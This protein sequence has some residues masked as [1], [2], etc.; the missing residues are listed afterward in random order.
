MPTEATRRAF[1]ACLAAAAVVGFAGGAVIGSQGGDAAPDGSSRTGAP[2]DASTGGEEPPDSG[3]TLAADPTTLPPRGIVTFSGTIAPA[4][5]GIQVKLQHRVGE[6]EWTDFPNA[7]TPI[8]PVSR[9]DGTFGGFVSP[10]QLG[11]N[12]YRV[13]QVDDESRVSN[14]VEITVAE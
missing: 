12:S 10:E 8:A 7:D 13:V 14:E 9:A 2:D 5:A 6:G 3:I 1:A 4:E 11:P